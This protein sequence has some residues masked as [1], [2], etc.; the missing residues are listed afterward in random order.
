MF[1]NNTI[2][3]L[4]T[5]LLFRVPYRLPDEDIKICLINAI[6]SLIVRLFFSAVSI[7]FF[8]LLKLDL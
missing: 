7:W 2:A 4:K 1:F 6:V 3:G 8:N 5:F